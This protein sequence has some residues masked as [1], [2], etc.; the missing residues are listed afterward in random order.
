MNQATSTF[1]DASKALRVLVP[2]VWPV[3]IRRVSMPDWGDCTFV[4]ESK[5][6]PMFIIRVSKELDEDCAI[7]ILLHEWA[8]ALSWGSDSHRIRSHGPEWGIA[9]SR[10]WQAMIED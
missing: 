10:I 6:G 5:K 8:H 7:M 4:K 2:L 3:S 1:R 9:M